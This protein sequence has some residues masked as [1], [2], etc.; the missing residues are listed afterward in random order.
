VAVTGHPE[1]GIYAAI[2]PPLAYALVG[3]SR[4]LIVNPDSAC[5]AILAATLAPLAVPGT[6]RYADLAVVLALLVGVLCIAGGIARLGVV[7]NFLS[8]PILAGYMNGIALSIIAG[9][10]E[11]L[12]RFTTEARGFF[13][14]LF[15]IGSRIGD[16]H[17][18]T[19]TLGA[20]LFALLFVL[21]RVAPRIPGPLVASVV[22]I[23]AVVTLNLDAMGVA[24]V[25]VLPAGLPVPRLPDMAVSDLRSL[26]FGA[27]GMA[28]LAYCSMIPTVRGFAA[29][30]GY[31]V[32]PNREFIALGACNFAAGV[33]QGFVVS[34]ADSRTV[35]A[36][37]AGGKTQLTGIVAAVVMALVLLFF[38][39]PLT[40]LP[41]AGLAAI[42]VF[43]VL[44]LFDFASLGR[45]YRLVRVEW[46]LSIVIT[47][48][49]LTIGL[50]P[51]IVLAVSLAILKL[52][53]LASFPHDAVFGLVRT[54]TGSYATEEPEGQRVAGLL[55]YR[56]DASL[57]RVD[58]GHSLAKASHLEQGSFGYDFRYRGETRLINFNIDASTS[59]SESDPSSTRMLTNF[60]YQRYLERSEWNPIGIGQ[61]E[62][63]DELAIDR[64]LSFGGGM[65]RY[66]RDTNQSRIAFAGGLLRSLEDDA[67]SSETID[68][69]EALLAMNLEWFQYDEPE[70]DVS[71][72]F[73]LYRRL[74]GS[75]EPRGN[76]DLSFRWEIFK[77]FFW[78]VSVYYTYDGQ[79]Q[80][81]E[82]AND[83]GSF[84]S[85]GWKF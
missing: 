20:A 79:A 23:V 38:T 27:S 14:K 55:I 29:K 83:Y 9:Q 24:L 12:L 21:K 65:A 74:S 11:P 56:F 13:R 48:G 40:L 47:L 43:A 6:Q 46:V 39:A 80:N 70:L 60:N 82:E 35:V 45:Y 42:V 17:I 22:G 61:L 19:V 25:G 28:I 18:P 4:Q 2:F 16:I 26:L 15:E 34:G 75:E 78:G 68:D 81:E 57:L 58:L 31:V 49:V 59:S 41:K 53:T 5:C 67:G 76:V 54:A 7:A 72:A 64:R 69:T 10:L 73:L 1:V 32:D 44:G 77:D 33:G 52:L 36:D 3:T 84:T 62:R 66:L 50:L 30:N 8:R 85:L 71:L 63:N 51:G 37:A